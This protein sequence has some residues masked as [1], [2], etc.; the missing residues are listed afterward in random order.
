MKRSDKHYGHDY[1]WFTSLIYIHT[2]NSVVI[3][4]SAKNNFLLSHLPK[5]GASQVYDNETFVILSLPKIWHTFIVC[6]CVSEGFFL[7]VF[8]ISVKFERAQTKKL[9]ASKKRWNGPLEMDS[10]IIRIDYD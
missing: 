4:P 1:I 2:T 6:L 5:G 8:P 9:L 3:G 7:T 10:T